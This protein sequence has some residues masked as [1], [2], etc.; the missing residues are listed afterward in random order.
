MSDIGRILHLT[1]G[2][3]FWVIVAES[4]RVDSAVLSFHLAQQ[5]GELDLSARISGRLYR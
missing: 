1:D 3:R 5:P 2:E 4:P